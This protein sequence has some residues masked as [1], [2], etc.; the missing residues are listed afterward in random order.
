[1]P[2]NPG[3]KLDQGYNYQEPAMEYDDL[4][5]P[6]QNNYNTK[7]FNEKRNVRYNHGKIVAFD[8]KMIYLF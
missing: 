2:Y 8:N 6:I 5:M 1:M 3:R 4:S 7:S